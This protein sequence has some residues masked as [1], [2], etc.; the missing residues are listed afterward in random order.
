[1]CQVFE[2]REQEHQMP[3][4]VI[5]GKSMKLIDH[6]GLE[7]LKEL[8]MLDPNRDQHGLDRF[9]RREQDLGWIVKHAPARRLPDIAV[10]EPN[11]HPEAPRVAL[12][13]GEKFIQSRL[14]G[15]QKETRQ[16]VPSLRRDGGEE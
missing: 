11:A 5:A 16:P 2:P 1:P 15:P 9:W 14:G 4:A 3:A 12:V 8:N 6:D 13:S 7:I 10:P